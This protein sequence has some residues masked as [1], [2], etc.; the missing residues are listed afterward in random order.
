MLTDYWTDMKTAMR[1]LS[2]EKR[3]FGE[4]MKTDVLI[5]IFFPEDTFESVV[6]NDIDTALGLFGEFQSR[7]SRFLK[8]NA[9]STLNQSS[10]I[11]RVSFEFADILSRAIVFWKETE[12]LFNPALLPQLLR[13]GYT[14]SFGSADFG[15]AVVT[16][17][18]LPLFENFGAL[19][20]DARHGLVEKP[21][22]MYLDL[23]GMGKGYIID[24]VGDFLTKKYEHFLIDAGG[25]HMRSRRGQK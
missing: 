20:V 25:G 8:E 17:S 10:G 15:K 6:Q 19:R 4:I 9:L 12:G 24:R 3:V 23:G 11:T 18:H 13:E 14:S 16:E 21:E 5:R 1:W 22:G 2:T 7:Y